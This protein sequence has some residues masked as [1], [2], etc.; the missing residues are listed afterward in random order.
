MA[1]ARQCD[2]CD[3]FY[4]PTLSGY[5]LEATANV[6]TG[7]SEWDLCSAR[8]LMHVA[9]ERSPAHPPEITTSLDELSVRF[10]SLLGQV[11]LTWSVMEVNDHDVMEAGVVPAMV[12]ADLF[13]TAG[14]QLEQLVGMTI[15]GGQQPDP[16]PEVE[17]Q[18]S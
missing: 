3:A 17:G 11:H 9:A 14:R 1:D 12:D 16:E 2:H 6:N 4:D 5:H 13:L 7:D 18:D 15:G 10:H 8:C